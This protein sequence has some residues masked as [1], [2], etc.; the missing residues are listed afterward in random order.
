MIKIFIGYDVNETIAYHVCVNS[1]IRHSSSLLSLT[2]LAL[3]NLSNYTESHTDGSNSFIYSRFLVPKLMNYTGWAL[4][5]DGDVIVQEDI[6]KLWNLRDKSKAVLCV[7]HNYKTKQIK[8][9]LGF[10]NENYP[11]KNWSSV[12]LWNCNHPE[13]R[14]LTLDYVASASGSTLHRF[15]WLKD[16]LIGELPSHWNWLPDEFG[17]NHEASLLHYTLGVPCF[18]DSS[19]TP[20]ASKWHEERVLTEYFKK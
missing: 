1:L 13:N 7:H 4:Y 2:P 17:E 9:Y 20:M 19:N 12:V 8:K 18:S 15:K 6:V 10:K 11:R 16:E 3:N 5:I 14:I